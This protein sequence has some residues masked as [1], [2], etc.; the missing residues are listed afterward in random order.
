MM[1]EIAIYRLAINHQRLIATIGVLTNYSITD[2]MTLVPDNASCLVVTEYHP[3]G[4]VQSWLKSGAF[5]EKL[6]LRIACEIADG[7]LE[8]HN[9]GVVHSDLKPSHIYLDQRDHA[10]VGGFKLSVQLPVPDADL[11]VPFAGG[12]PAY[13]APECWERN[14][15][16]RQADIYSFGILLH[17]MFITQNE[18]NTYSLQYILRDGDDTTD[19]LQVFKRR[20]TE[21]FRPMLPLR[22][23]TRLSAAVYDVVV[24]LMQKCWN[25]NPHA[26][27]DFGTVSLLLANVMVHE[28]FIDA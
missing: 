13:T 11:E 20:V 18:S 23:E 14:V 5:D 4:T 9:A 22:E 25:S 16:T 7:M 26:R 3:H 17:V 12:S 19:L 2:T 10:H 21:G 6:A 27:P 24:P 15:I 8:L 1:R 28:D